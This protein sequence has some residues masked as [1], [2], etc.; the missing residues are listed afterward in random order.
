MG[1][2]KDERAEN[3]RE[4]REEARWDLPTAAQGEDCCG[5]NRRERFHV[6]RARAAVTVESGFVIYHGVHPTNY[7]INDNVKH[8]CVCPLTPG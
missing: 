6:E 8:L 1:G 5:G 3:F 7:H 4:A 2:P